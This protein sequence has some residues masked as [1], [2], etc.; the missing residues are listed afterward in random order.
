MSGHGKIEPTQ[1]RA[2]VPNCEES[3]V[4]T[5][6]SAVQ[7]YSAPPAAVYA[8]F[9]SRE[10]QEG[11]LEAHGG[12]DPEVVSM[13]V[14]G[15]TIAVVTRQ[16]IPA[17]ALPSMVASMV[18]GNLG[19]QRTENWRPDGDGYVADFAVT[20]KG[21]PASM[22]GTM[23]LGPDGAGSVLTVAGQATVPIPLFGGKI[24]SVIV[25]QVGELMAAEESYTQ[26]RLGD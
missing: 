18:P 2:A 3:S 13:E 15:D 16:S 5:T 21:A 25:E 19:T 17:S 24:E 11:K 9:G 7:H 10:F 14:D 22:K 23:T 20:I 1:C 6:L 8:L 4:P 26:S 12:L